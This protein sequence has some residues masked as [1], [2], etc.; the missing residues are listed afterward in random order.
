[1][2][3]VGPS[4][5]KDGAQNLGGCRRQLHPD[6]VLVGGVA[7]QE[8]SANA[9]V[10]WTSRAA[11]KGVA[12][13]FGA[14]EDG[15]VACVALSQNGYHA[16]SGSDNGTVKMWDMRKAGQ[17]GALMATFGVDGSV[18]DLSYDHYGKYVAACGNTGV[19]VYAVKKWSAP[20]LVLRPEGPSKRSKKRKKANGDAAAAA[21]CLRGVL[22]KKCHV[23]GDGRNG[24]AI[25]SAI[26]K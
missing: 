16:A 24:P 12:G 23:V 14:H 18:H 13:T 26:A 5:G 2:A 21:E 6:G 20:L 15:P 8:S 1:M 25:S 10:M 9:V 11:G 19:D 17:D 22:G 3:D 7:R 4:H